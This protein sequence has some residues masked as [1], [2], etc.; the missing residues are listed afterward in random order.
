VFARLG[1]G[2]A[3]WSPP[4]MVPTSITGLFVQDVAIGMSSDVSLGIEYYTK[5]RHISVGLE[6]GVQGLYMPFAFGA[7]IYPTIKYTF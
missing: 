7:H 3:I 1:V 6:V 2:L 4:A 5:L